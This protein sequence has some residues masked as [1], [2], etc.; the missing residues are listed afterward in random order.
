[1][2]PKARSAERRL[3][4]VGCG[5][6]GSTV[7]RLLERRKS[8][9][10]ITAL[11]DERSAWAADLSQ[12]L[13]T[14]PQLCASLPELV[15]QVDWVLE[16]ASV[17]AVPALARLAL[18]GRK[19]LVVMSSGG[20]LSDF[21]KIERLAKKYKTKVYLPSGALAG[22]DG[23]KAARQFGKIKKIQIT[24]TKPPEGLKGA[25]G[26]T[27]AQKKALFT[28]KKPFYLYQGNVSG[29]IRR[30]P[31]NVNVGATLALASG[32]PSKV[33][34]EVIVDPAAKRNRHQIH[35]TGSFGEL[36]AET[37]NEPSPSN[38]KT[39]ALAI[40][41]ALALFERIESFV[42]IGN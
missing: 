40:Q 2:N 12:N 13:K 21:S 3:G 26:I 22:L 29:A 27:A 5:A 33:R 30:F 39:S 18:R 38:P 17:R 32:N 6:I 23:V 31:A 8:S 36:T 20:L 11:Y 10:R 42:E 41:A 15:S 19:P 28:A 4:I 7:A 34:V 1:M 9:F 14:R 37:S 24:T 16:A 35:V 25:P